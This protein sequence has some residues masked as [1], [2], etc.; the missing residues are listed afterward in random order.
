MYRDVSQLH[1]QDE[2]NKLI[3][4]LE[5][6][7]INLPAIYIEKEV[8]KR[9][10]EFAN[11]HQFRHIV[12]VTDDNTKKVVGDE[13]TLFL[14]KEGL[15]TQL[16]I[17]TPTE[18]NQVIA[19]EETLVEL[20]LATSPETTL[21]IAAG[22]GTIH[23]I[24]RFV[25]HKM[26]IPF[27]SVPTAASVDGFTS[28]GAPLILR[29][30]KQTIQTASPIAVF[31]DINILVRAPRELTAAGFGDILGKYTSL[32]DWE[33]SRLIANEP[34]QARAAAMTRYALD[35]CINN[36]EKIAQRDEEGIK[37]IIQALIESGLVMLVL[38]YS[39]PASGGEHHLSH[40]LE[41]DMLQKNQKQHLHGAKVGVTTAI[42]AEL[43]KK[44]V[45]ESS[46]EDI[47]N[48]TV[49]KHWRTIKELILSIPEAEQLRSYLRKVGGPDSI[50]ALK[51]EDK[52]V[53]ASLNQAHNLRDRCTGLLLINQIKKTEL[54]Y[55]FNSSPL[56]M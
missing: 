27:I 21:L 22:S 40:F 44:F 28:K 5:C 30:K 9:I 10:P 38:D 1:F 8:I 16:V 49:K 35:T 18:H 3:K 11:K 47:K 23:D 19:N 53:R 25:G 14:E 37:I 13:L 56:P 43:Y 20:M 6:N 46:L 15:I 51:I 45:T 50:Q 17:L 42:I 12:I 48:G 24:V 36:I 7:D 29:G 52:V 54:P 39:R 33:I 31:A 55:P 32:V 41:M 2:L 34:Y 4:E 26:D